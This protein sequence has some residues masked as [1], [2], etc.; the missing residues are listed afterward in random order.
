MTKPELR[1]YEVSVA[2][3]P[4]GDHECKASVYVDES[5]PYKFSL[6]IPVSCHD[7]IISGFR[8]VG[9]IN[10]AAPGESDI[11]GLPKSHRVFSNIFDAAIRQY[12]DTPI[13]A[14]KQP[15]EVPLHTLDAREVRALVMRCNRAHLAQQQT[16]MEKATSI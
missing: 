16:P 12:L 3:L 7:S 11:L 4:G 6:I 10:E 2:P 15:A 14:M 5:G 1:I 9:L 8:A 13:N